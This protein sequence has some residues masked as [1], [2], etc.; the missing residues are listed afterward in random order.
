LN[1]TIGH[2]RTLRRETAHAL[3]RAAAFLL[4]L[5]HSA[6]ARAPGTTLDSFDDIAG[7][8]GVTSH[9]S[10]SHVSLTSVRGR[11]GNAMLIEYAF[12]GHMGSAA[13]E[14][15]F[16][17]RLPANYQISFDLRGEGPP[18]NFVIR[19]MDSLGNVWW[20]NR[21]NFVFPASWTRMTIRKSQIQYGWGP[22]GG[23]DLRALDRFMLMVDVVEGGKG[24]IWIENLC[25]EPL[26]EGGNPPLRVLASSSE[27]GYWPHPDSGGNAVTGWRSLTGKK[28][29]WLQADCGRG[30][31]LGGLVVVWEKGRRAGSFDVL[32]SDDGRSWRTAYRAVECGGERSCVF[33]G[34]SAPRFIRLNLKDAGKERAFGIRRLDLK[35]PE[36]GFSVNDFF[37]GIAS[38]SPR[39][40]Y[41]RYL[42]GE[43]SYWTIVG[44]PGD[45][46]KALVNEQGMIETD[47]LSCS[48]EP[49]LYTE[50][51]LTTWNDAALTQHL[52]KEYLPIPSVRWQT[53]DSLLLTTTALAAGTPGSSSLLVRYSVANR[54]ARRREGKLFVAMRP[55]QVNPPWQT[56]TIVG[57]VARID[58]ISYDGAVHLNG[59]SVVPLTE[60]S[61]FGAAQFDAGELTGYLCEGRVPPARGVIDHFGYAS[62]ALRYDFDIP[63]GGSKEVVLGIPWHGDRS[64]GLPGQ[65][66]PEDAPLW[67]DSVLAG[68]SASWDSLLHGV[69]ITLPREAGAIVN[70]VKSNLAYI[71]INADGPALQPGARTYQRSWVRDGA[72]T[73]AALL[74]MGIDPPVR[75]YIDWYATYQY[76]DGMIPAVVESRGPEPTPEHDSHGEFLYMIREYFSFSRDTAWLKGKWGS[77]WKTFRYIQS[78]RNERKTD[79]Y[80]RGT[81]LERACYGLVP[82]SISH[83][84]YCPA[85][86]HSYWDDFFILRGL[87]DAALIAPLAGERDRAGLIA[88]ERDDCGADLL[89]SL[90]QAILNTGVKFIPGCA[91]L[92][93]FSG[94]S[95][96]VAVTPCGVLD[97]MPGEETRYTFDESYRMFL[98]RRDN[99]VAWDSY[100]PYEARFIGAYVMLNEKE[101]AEAIL[102]YLMHDRRP[103]AWNEWAEVVWKNPRAPKSIGDMPHSWAASDFIR[104]FRTMLAYERERDSSLILCP[105]IPDA[106]VRD[107]AGVTVRNLPTHFGPLTYALRSDGN[108]VIVEIGAGTDMPPGNIR[109]RSPLTAS[110][111]EITGAAPSAAD[112]REAIVRSLPARVVFTY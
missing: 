14:K 70:T 77:V 55:F 85:P 4:L 20:V 65:V 56:F 87:R 69:D 17:V 75:R 18:N 108:R 26:Y 101:R 64:P 103:Q 74:E 37:R 43:Q 31:D 24:R 50:G 36:F 39:G 1:L 44:A 47:K 76:P 102:D 66:R 34:E 54:S 110:P 106:W 10:A 27:Q 38:E 45:S 35:G 96:T 83:E 42:C 13:A 67:F 94:L 22:S 59:I 81:P 25:M 8:H 112:P 52:E 88:A 5:P 89:A 11:T 33:L 61:A 92:G 105:G 58:T 109:V 3:F 104:S 29:A 62:A 95:T 71:L 53:N 41:P 2:R 80:R 16:G 51:G 46:R 7:W 32:L 15:R 63:P 79:R 68:V 90:R 107:P 12:L 9:G 82:A 60:P 91:E 48:L 19:L 6:P 84:G 86:M 21:S 57:G 28:E 73:S 99:S 93:D 30:R 97:V 100:L 72:L 98:A 23:G 78:L 49:F 111:A 40:W